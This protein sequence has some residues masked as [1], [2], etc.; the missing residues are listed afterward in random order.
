MYHGHGGMGWGGWL[1]VSLTLVLSSGAIVALVAWAVRNFRSTPGDTEAKPFRTDDILAERFARGEIDED[2][3][4]R[5]RELLRSSQSR[6]G[7]PNSDRR[8]ND[9]SGESAR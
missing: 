2:E 7:A 1:A 8:D 4:T 3:F 5:R 9:D 6:S